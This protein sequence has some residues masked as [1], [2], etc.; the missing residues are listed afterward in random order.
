[1]LNMKI[2]IDKSF[3]DLYKFVKSKSMIKRNI[4]LIFKIGF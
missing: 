3:I 2:V 1:M 4:T